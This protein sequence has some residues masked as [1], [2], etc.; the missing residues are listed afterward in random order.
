MLAAG[1]LAAGLVGSARPL[2]GQETTGSTGAAAA[3]AALG[4]YTGATLGG[5]ASLIPCNQTYAGV[6]CVRLGAALGA[7]LGLISGIA[8][9]NADEDRVRSAYRRGGIG[10]VAGSA[11]V[12]ALKPF[13]D[14]WSWGDVA[15]GA[16]IGSALGAGGTGAWVGL[17][18]GMGVGVGAWKLFPSV[19]LPDA[20]GIGLVGMAAGAFTSWIVQAVDAGSDGGGASGTFLSFSFGS[21]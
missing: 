4:L 20:I 10:L 6:R 8:L 12:L 15:A 11:A 2:R 21:P 19:E 7:G 9:G 3:G 14:R 1:L 13:V 5:M 16:V 17:V 18:L